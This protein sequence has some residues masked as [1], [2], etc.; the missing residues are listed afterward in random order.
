MKIDYWRLI[1]WFCETPYRSL[2]RAHEV[3]KQVLFTRKKYL[4]HARVK[5]SL[6]ELSEA[7]LTEGLHLSSMIYWNLLEYRTSIFISSIVEKITFFHCSQLSLLTNL[8]H[9]TK[10]TNVSP[11]N[12]NIIKDEKCEKSDPGTLISHYP[13]ISQSKSESRGYQHGNDNGATHIRNRID[14][15]VSADKS[16]TYTP[17]PMISKKYDQMNRKL[18]WI[19]AVPNDLVAV[20]KCAVTSHLP[21]DNGSNDIRVPELTNLLLSASAYELTNLIPRSINR[22]LFNFGTELASQS[23]PLVLHDFRLAKYQ[24]AASLKITG[25]LIIFFFM[26][27]AILKNE[28]SEPWVEQLR[29]ISQLQVFFNPFQEERAS[30]Q[31]RRTEGLRWLDG[32]TN[33]SVGLRLQNCD[34]NTCDGNIQSV[35]MYNKL[36]IQL[37]SCI[38]SDAISL[39]TPIFVFAVSRRRLAALNPWIR[40]LFY[41]SSDTTKAFS[42]LLVTD[43]CVGFHSPQGWEIVTGCFLE[44]LGFARDKYVISCFVST[45][46]VISDTVSKYWIFRHLN[47]ASPSIVATYHTTNE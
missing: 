38:V 33:S 47:R 36:N 13:G 23:T 45:F 42:I 1:Q 18:V 15:F 39:V 12:K 26:I 24:A 2:D 34:I 19:E 6:K 17:M 21:T 31:F 35:I 3:S 28:F 4:S 14:D 40:E 9:T 27:H 41:S 43:P 22:T 32:I 29:N 8:C 5:S 7:A 16:G 37:V 30:N 46:P 25:C 44:H 10:G 11:N 20:R